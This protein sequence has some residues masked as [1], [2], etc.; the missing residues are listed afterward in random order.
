VGGLNTTQIREWA[1]ALSIEV[2]R[3][4]VPVVLVAHITAAIGQQG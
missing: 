1:R 4:R 2:S 3:G